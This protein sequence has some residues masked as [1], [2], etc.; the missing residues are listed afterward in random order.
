MTAKAPI[1]VVGSPRSGTTW[2]GDILSSGAGLRQ[3]Y[4]PFNK[5]APDPLG[6]HRWPFRDV[7]VPY[8][9][10]G[11]TNRSFEEATRRLLEQRLPSSY[12]TRPLAGTLLRHRRTISEWLAPIKEQT[13]S[14][15]RHERLLI[16]DP[17][18]THLARWL[19]EVLGASIIYVYRHPGGV[20][21]GCKRMGWL[22]QS[23][24]ILD[25]PLLMRDLLEPV[26]PELETAADRPDDVI[27]C[28]LGMWVAYTWPL[29]KL[30]DR[31]DAIIPVS[32]ET[33][34]TDPLRSFAHICDAIDI[35]LSTALESRLSETTSGN[36]IQ[37]TETA[38]HILE[39][40]SSYT[41]RSWRDRLSPGEVDRVLAGTERIR[42]NLAD[43]GLAI[44]A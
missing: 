16:K 23:S 19:I 18:A 15:W 27:S 20:A 8:V 24:W 32:Y 41:A 9:A 39:R 42:Q 4:E 28:A 5:W 10:D 35:P 17:R 33:L 38:Q 40:D 34:A 36:H 13:A 25:N 2:I 43:V 30:K 3:I 7:Y 1:F 29:V 37:S 11:E 14:R 22:W 26:R 6:G 44:P 31:Y 12:F 21:A